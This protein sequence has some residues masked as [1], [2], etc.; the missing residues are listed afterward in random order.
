M[1]FK[2]CIEYSKFY[3]FDLKYKKL[4]RHKKCNHKKSP[5]NGDF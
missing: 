2:N 4:F 3:L 1:I 5:V